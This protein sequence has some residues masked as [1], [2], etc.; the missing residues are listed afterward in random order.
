MSKPVAIVTGAASGLGLAVSKHLITKG[1]RVMMIDVNQRE[2][3]RLQ[4]ELGPDVMFQ[5]CDV[6]IYAEQAEA[7]AKAFAWGEGRLDFL[8]ANAGID[9]RQYLYE[10]NESMAID[11]NGVPLELN[12]K[13]MRVDLDAV[14][15]GIWLFKYY[16]R[17]NKRQKGGKIVI[18]ASAAGL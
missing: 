14:M 12:M 13:A 2:G 7:F 1:Y 8:A 3:E 17:M 10:S 15:Q 6:S 9:D 11:S 4:V 5:R 18:T 16:A